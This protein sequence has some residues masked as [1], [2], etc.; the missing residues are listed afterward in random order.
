MAR[1][2]S[3]PPPVTR[4]SRGTTS[5]A[6]GDAEGNLIAVTQTLSTWGGTFYVSKGL[7]FLYNNHLRRTAGR[8][9]RQPGPLM[10][11]TTGTVPT[12]VF[13]QT[14]GRGC[15]GWPWAAPATPGFRSRST[16]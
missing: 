12:L 9:V 1:A 7:G 5:F 10:R 13:E 14:D 2:P 8:R 15:R 4:I 3:S 11:S 16:T 6:V